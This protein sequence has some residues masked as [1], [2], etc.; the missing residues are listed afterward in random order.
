MTPT[1]QQVLEAAR[2]W[3]VSRRPLTWSERKHI[4]NP[5]VNCS[6]KAVDGLLAQAVAFWVDENRRSDLWAWLIKVRETGRSLRRGKASDGN[7]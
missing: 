6:Q 3:W 5:L 4:N 1:E 2:R 7:K